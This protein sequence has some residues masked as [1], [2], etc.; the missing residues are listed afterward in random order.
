MIGL[1]ALLL[2][3]PAG[4]NAPVTGPGALCLKYSSFELAPGER[5][6]K[7]T[8][9]IENMQLDIDGPNGRYTITESELMGGPAREDRRIHTRPDAQV[10]AL[11]GGG[12]AFR[13]VLPFSLHGA[14]L[15]E[16]V[17][18]FYVS[19]RG[20]ALDR[21]QSADPILARLTLGTPTTKDCLM[22]YQ[23]G[24]EFFLPAETQ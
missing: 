16:P 23:Y 8:L 20:H 4:Q 11:R 10:Y 6:A 24:W 19:I 2:T 15:A 9:A 12:Y 22:R 1:L 13:G 14:P 5:V 18:Q 3:F 21:R 17:D 7:R